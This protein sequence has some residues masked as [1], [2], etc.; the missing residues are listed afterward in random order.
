VLW[1]NASSSRSAIDDSIYRQLAHRFIIKGDHG[2]VTLHCKKILGI[3]AIAVDD[4]KVSLI[5]ENLSQVKKS[6]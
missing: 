3:P 1:D 6:T 5:G 2:P 4:D